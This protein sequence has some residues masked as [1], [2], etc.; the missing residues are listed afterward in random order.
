MWFVPGWAQGEESK[1]KQTEVPL[2]EV[3]EGQWDT[4]RQNCQWCKKKKRT[5]DTWEE[6]ESENPNLVGVSGKE[7]GLRNHTQNQCDLLS[8]WAGVLREELKMDPLLVLLF[9]A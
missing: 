5:E 3:L 7:E 6:S 4:E 8:G 2:P 1:V 9:S